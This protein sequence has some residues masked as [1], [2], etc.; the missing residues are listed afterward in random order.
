MTAAPNYFPTVGFA[1]EEGNA[2]A[3]RS[4]I[5]T[6]ALDIELANISASINLLNAN[7]QRLQRD[8]G[9]LM[10]MII[11]PYAL[12][13]QL[14]SLIAA[15]GS[16]KGDWAAS[17]SYVIGDCVSYE[18]IAYL[19]ITAH[20]STV[21]FDASKFMAISSAANAD[22]SAIAAAASASIA[23]NS[24]VGCNAA[25]AGMTATL[26]YRAT[27]ESVTGD[28]ITAN[29]APV[30]TALSDGLTVWVGTST[31][32]TANISATPT[33][34]ANATEAKTIVKWNN[35]A[36]SPGDIAMGGQVLLLQYRS[37]LDRWVLLNPF[38]SDLYASPYVKPAYKSN[39]YYWAGFNPGSGISGSNSVQGNY[40]SAAPFLARA[41]L[42]ISAYGIAAQIASGTANARV[43]LYA[44]NNGVPGTL[45]NSGGPYTVT[46]TKQLIQKTGVSIPLS[47]GVTYW[48]A[49]LSNVTILCDGS[50]GT[51]NVLY[52]YTDP[53]AGY[54]AN[55]IS[56]SQAY[57][58]LPAAFPT[59]ITYEIGSSGILRFFV[60]AL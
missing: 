54:S 53:L 19:C 49:I 36:L 21:S 48:L 43:G 13:E 9:L 57:G 32:A 3:G 35:A 37:A 14:K 12:S 20:I 6:P 24:L 10:D 34:A 22:A 26:L 52:G 59:A 58:D 50:G 27:S 42:T 17:T 46:T 8:D 29:F 60:K 1:G 30:I 18:G 33:F 16:P 39:R 55:Y 41:N 45:L 23:A 7:L 25:L 31:S 28:V 38:F 11:Q 2:V 56:A 40:L 44:D 4:T 5:R 15:K 47:K 51:D